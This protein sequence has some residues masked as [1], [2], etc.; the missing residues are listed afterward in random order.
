MF[1]IGYN[2]IFRVKIQ[3][4]ISLK[5]GANT[6]ARTTYNRFIFIKQA[7]VIKGTYAY[8]H[9]VIKTKHCLRSVTRFQD[10]V[11]YHHRNR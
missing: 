10:K 7:I 1:I 9:A 11:A 5:T 8:F 2:K 6:I 4:A 3:D